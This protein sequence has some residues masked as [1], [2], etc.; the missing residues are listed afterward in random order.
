MIYS[1]IKEFQFITLSDP[2]VIYKIVQNLG[3][4]FQKVL[5]KRDLLMINPHFEMIFFSK[6]IL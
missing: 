1:Q 3:K 6:P 4:K 5:K 2:S